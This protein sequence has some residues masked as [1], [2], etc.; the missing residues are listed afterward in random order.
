MGKE[1]NKLEKLLLLFKD[2][3]INTFWLDDF[4]KPLPVGHVLWKPQF[5]NLKTLNSQ[6]ISLYAELEDTIK[7]YSQ[8]KDKHIYNKYNWDMGTIYQVAMSNHEIYFVWSS[9]DNVINDLTF[10]IS[11]IKSMPKEDK[12]NKSSDNFWTLIHDDIIKV[13]QNRF[14]SWEYADAV[15][16]AFKHINSIV[17]KICK[18]RRWEEKDWS[19]LMKYTFSLNNP[20]IKLWNL[21]SQDG[22]SIQLWYM[23][24]FAWSMT[25][26]RNPKA[27]DNLTISKE[28]CIHFLFLASL[29]RTKID[30]EIN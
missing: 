9:L 15:E 16:S 24:I 13:T 2:Y 7:K 22:K 20:V 14:N 21:N 28:K 18:K 12:T 30:E 11:K 26:I 23:E 27:H 29:L 10:I 4:D 1:I 25:G 8:F 5:S 17:K 3:K 19:D 6:I